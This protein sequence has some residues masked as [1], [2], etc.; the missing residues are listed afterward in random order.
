MKEE[1]LEDLGKGEYY[2]LSPKEKNYYYERHYLL[3]NGE[4]VKGIRAAS[5]VDA[6]CWMRRDE[7]TYLGIGVFHE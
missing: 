1:D 3:R 4:I 7:D 5:K 2:I 6:C